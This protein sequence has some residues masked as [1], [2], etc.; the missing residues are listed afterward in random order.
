GGDGLDGDGGGEL[1]G[2]HG[3]DAIEVHGGVLTGV[4]LHGPDHVAE[5]LAVGGDLSG[6]LAGGALSD[7][8]VLI[9]QNLHGLNLRGAGVQRGDVEVGD[10]VHGGLHNGLH[11]AVGGLSFPGAVVDVSAGAFQSDD[12]IA[13]VAVDAQT[14]IG[15]LGQVVAVGLHQRIVGGLHR[16]SAADGSGHV[17]ELVEGGLSL[18]HQQALHGIVA[19]FQSLQLLDG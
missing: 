14:L 16:H 10:G 15:G 1:V 2:I 19:V 8:H 11:L 13:G 12:L 3:Q 18:L 17:I 6:E 4:A 9:G 5:V 7:L